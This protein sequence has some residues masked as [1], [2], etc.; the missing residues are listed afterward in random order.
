MREGNARIGAG[1][2]VWRRRKMKGFTN[3]VDF[4][5]AHTNGNRLVPAVNST[6]RSWKNMEIVYAAGFIGNT[7]THRDS[8]VAPGEMT[9]IQ[10]RD[11]RIIRTEQIAE[12]DTFEVGPATLYFEPGDGSRGVFH[13]AA[14]VGRV[15]F[16][17]I[18]RAVGDGAIE[19][20]PSPQSGDLALL[21]E[22]DLA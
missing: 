10:C 16:P 7:D 5:A 12:G 1:I 19:F 14:A 9:E 22:G 21:E 4:N 3:E 11:D 13:T 18:V 20:Q 2:A 17:V 6:R 15:P 8:E